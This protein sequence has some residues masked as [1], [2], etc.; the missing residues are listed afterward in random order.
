MI[1]AGREDRGLR[2]SSGERVKRQISVTVWS[3]VI[4]WVREY[5]YPTE[6][7]GGK[8]RNGSSL[9]SRSRR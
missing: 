4:G 5:L 6:M 9:T 3:L 7:R 2:G 8:G 1:T